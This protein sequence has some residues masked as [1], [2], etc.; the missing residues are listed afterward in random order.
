MPSRALVIVVLFASALWPLHALA[1]SNSMDSSAVFT[2]NTFWLDLVLWT[3]G[4]VFLNRVVIA[5]VWGPATASPA[6]SSW[7]GRFFFLLV[8]ACLVLLFAT[9]T[10]GGPVLNLSANKMSGCLTNRSMLWVLMASPAV[11]FV[12]Q[13]VVFQKWDQQLFGG[14]RLIAL[15]ALVLT[16]V[17]LAGGVDLARE[18]VVL[19]ELCRP[20]GIVV[21]A[22]TY[23]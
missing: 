23:D 5:N 8:G 10:A 21:G 3:I 13:A 6:G 20:S 14:D 7:V 12:L 9:V 4:A 17:V 19:P 1:C 18:L 16:S 15:A 11:V 22:N 2:S